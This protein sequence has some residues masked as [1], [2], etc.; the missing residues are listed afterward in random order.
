MK[1]KRPAY[2]C[3]KSRDRNKFCRGFFLFE[4]MLKY[5]FF[6]KQVIQIPMS[7][8]TSTPIDF[9][10]LKKALSYIILPCFKLGDEPPPF[11]LCAPCTRPLPPV[12]APGAV[13]DHRLGAGARPAG[14]H[15]DLRPRPL[16]QLLHRELVA[17]DRRQD[18]G[19]HARHV[20]PRPGAQ[21]ARGHQHAHR[22]CA[23]SR[24]SD[25]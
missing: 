23:A 18:P 9:D 25:S 6:H 17:V 12:A 22:R 14:G 8:V 24:L 19:A 1:P 16:R 20:P 10:V 7:I 2:F 11:D 13:R 4:I 21:A 15:V 5:S 3:G